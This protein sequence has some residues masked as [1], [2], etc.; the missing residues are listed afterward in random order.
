MTLLTSDQIRRIRETTDALQL[1]WDAVVVPL[2]ASSTPF[3]RVMVDGKLLIRPPGGAAFDPW[4]S[5][6]R[7]RL[8]SLEL[9]R[10]PRAAVPR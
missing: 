9:E 2:A 7:D 8:L 4:F 5:G 3:E 6:L 10:V 1:D